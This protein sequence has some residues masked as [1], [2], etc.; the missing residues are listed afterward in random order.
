MLLS[1]GF[2]SNTVGI[3][4]PPPVWCVRILSGRRADWRHMLAPRGC[5]QCAVSLM[6]LMPCRSLLL[7]VMT[8]L[9]ASLPALAGCGP[10]ERHFPPLAAALLTWAVAVGRPPHHISLA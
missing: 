9:M 1:A 3:R 10:R 2:L 5:G 6:E 4:A 8:L 7:M